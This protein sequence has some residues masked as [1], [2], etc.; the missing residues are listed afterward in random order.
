MNTKNHTIIKNVFIAIGFLIMGIIL[1]K[2]IRREIM[3]L[4]PRSGYFFFNEIKYQNYFQQRYIFSYLKLKKIELSHSKII[5]DMVFLKGTV[6][7]DN[8]TRLECLAPIVQYK[9]IWVH[10][11]KKKTV[12]LDQNYHKLNSIIPMNS[13]NH[14]IQI[15]IAQKINS[16]LW[17]K[18]KN[19]KGK[20]IM[21]YK[22]I[23]RYQ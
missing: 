10:N 9:I 1:G 18:L 6:F 21:I 14:K 17:K 13:I 8:P 15:K 3:R 4:F 12:I 22:F 5:D 11:E 2:V 7:I 19:K 23:E 16:N 20:V